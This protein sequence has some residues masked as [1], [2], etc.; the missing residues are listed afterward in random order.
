[1]TKFLIRAFSSLSQNQLVYLI[2]ITKTLASGKE[3][4]KPPMIVGSLQID[5]WLTLGQHPTVVQDALDVDEV[6]V[7]VAAEADGLVYRRC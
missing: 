3:S 1:M 6:G 4:R 7:V 2:S 5:S